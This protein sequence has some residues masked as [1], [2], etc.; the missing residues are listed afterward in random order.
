MSAPGK[1]RPITYRPGSTSIW[2]RPRQLLTT[3][4]GSVPAA[5]HPVLQHFRR[6]REVFLRRLGHRLAVTVL[7][8]SLFRRGIFARKRQPHQAARGLPRQL[9]AIEQHLTEHRLGLMLALLGGQPKP[10]GAITEIVAGRTCAPQVK[11]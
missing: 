10:A 1:S 11:P 8:P 4:A 2:K 7:D 9:I 6:H 3:R 5:L